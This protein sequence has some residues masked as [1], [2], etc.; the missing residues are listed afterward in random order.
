MLNEFKQFAMRGNVVDLAVGVIIGTAFGKIISSLVNDILMPPIGLVLG[1][2]DFTNLFISMNRQA[3]ASLA[4]AQAAG[5]PTLNY[6]LFINTII[7]FIIVA[8]VIFM[9]IRSINRL[10]RPA[11]AAEPVTKECAY[12]YSTIPVKATRCPHCTSQL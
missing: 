2:V 4:E 6:G 1:N 12:C 7:D 9:L 10:Q 8:F 3:Y 5:A 11:P